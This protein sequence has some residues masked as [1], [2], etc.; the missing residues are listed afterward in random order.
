[1]T[2]VIVE[3]TLSLDGFIAGPQVNKEHAMGIGGDRLHQWIF[4]GKSKG[5]EV[6]LEE[7]K[8]MTGAVIIGKTMFDVGLQYWNDTPYPVPTFVMTHKPLEKLSMKSSS[9]TFLTTGIDDALIQAKAAA[10]KKNVLIMGGANIA[11]Q[12]IKSQTFDELWVH[13]APVLLGEGVRLFERIGSDH[14]EL[15]RISLVG[16]KGMTHMKF[17]KA[18]TTL[19]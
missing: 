16:T 8:Q 6:A 2:S 19:S 11:Q 1:M 9:F 7:T 3:M 18:P 17:R 5:D 10:G 12:Y 15:E 13:I 4:E 14:I